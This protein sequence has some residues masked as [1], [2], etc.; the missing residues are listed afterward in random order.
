MEHIG[1]TREETHRVSEII[2]GLDAAPLSAGS[3]RRIRPRVDYVH[4][5]WLCLPEAA[6]RPWAHVH[7]RN[8]S[9]GGLAFL[10]RKDFKTGQHV[11]VSHYVG[12]QMPHLVLACVRFS[13]LVYVGICEVGIEFLAAKP[14]P[15]QRREIPAD[16]IQT[17]MRSAW[18]IQHA[19]PAGARS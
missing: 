2:A 5:M 19:M 4:A 15:Q 12:E 8:L 18:E 6:G 9:T 11:V 7:S 1:L 14:D 17:A 16:W 13:R 3:E 10:T